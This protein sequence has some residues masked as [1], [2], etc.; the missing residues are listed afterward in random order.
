MLDYALEAS[1]RLGASGNILIV[2]VAIYSSSNSL[3]QLKLVGETLYSCTPKNKL[4]GRV[5]SI[6]FTPLFIFLL[7]LLSV[8]L[9][10]FSTRFLSIFER[11]IVNVI[12]AIALSLG[13]LFIV[14]LINFCACP[15]KTNLKCVL[16]GSVYTAILSVLETLIFIIYIR[17]FASIEKIYGIISALFVFISWLYLVIKTV[18]SGITL[19]AYRLKNK[20]EKSVDY[21]A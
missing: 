11:E 2:L 14:V 17:H 1:L 20:N 9:T 12:T 21:K 6:I 8:A 16:Q 19:N 3:Y 5:F 18:V 10:V 15:F 4:K 7:A 13:W